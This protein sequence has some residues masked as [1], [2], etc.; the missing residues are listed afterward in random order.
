M[1]IITDV[2][3]TVALI[4]DL[5]Q[6]QL[7]Q[8]VRNVHFVRSMPNISIYPANNYTQDYITTENT[9]IINEY[10]NTVISLRKLVADGIELEIS[11]PLSS[12]QTYCTQLNMIGNKKEIKLDEPTITV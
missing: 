8:V 2:T 1:K 9:P 10:N 12:T 4:G 11:Q 5:L 3:V 6:V 7:N